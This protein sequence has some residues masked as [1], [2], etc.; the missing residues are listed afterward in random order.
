[1][2]TRNQVLFFTAAFILILS[3]QHLAAKPSFSPG[4]IK[5]ENMPSYKGTENAVDYKWEFLMPE[6][7]SYLQ[8][9]SLNSDN[10]RL[11]NDNL[12]LKEY[13]VK[14]YTRAEPIAPGNPLTR[15][16][17]RKPAI[18][19]AIKTIEKYYLA[20]IRKNEVPKQEA[21][22]GFRK[23]LEVAVAASSENTQSF[24]EVLQ[25]NRRDAHKLIE[26]FNLVKLTPM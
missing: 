11:G 15:I 24:E 3:V 26:M 25:K 10:Y 16:V 18:F 19:N 9:N 7:K 17:I 2:K 1:M 8:E 12:C 21:E 22:N 13:I 6:M 14:K 5:N 20:G 4:G 23:V